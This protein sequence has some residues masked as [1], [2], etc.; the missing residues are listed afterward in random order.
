QHVRAAP[1]S[2]PDLR[3][4]LSMAGERILLPFIPSHG[5]VDFGESPDQSLI[6]RWPDAA[7]HGSSR[8]GWPDTVCDAIGAVAD[9]HRADRRDVAEFRVHAGDE[10]AGL[11]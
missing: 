4:N 8:L 6:Q 1:G 7:C 5:R 11:V 9:L 2:I 3:I 10:G